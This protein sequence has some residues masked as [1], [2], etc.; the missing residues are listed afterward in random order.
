MWQPDDDP[1][2]GREIRLMQ[3]DG[4]LWVEFSIHPAFGGGRM[5]VLMQPESETTARLPGPL[6][7]GGTLLS[8]NSKPGEQTRVHYSGLELVRVGD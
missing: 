2:L 6:A 4:R 1:I 3:A 7:D 8:V 5:R